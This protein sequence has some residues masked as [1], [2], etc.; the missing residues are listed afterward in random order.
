MLP[1]LPDVNDWGN[2]LAFGMGDTWQATNGGY[3]IGEHVRAHRWMVL[4][5]E[6]KAESPLI[7]QGKYW[8]MTT[9]QAKEFLQVADKL[10]KEENLAVYAPGAE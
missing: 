7:P 2:M 4:L 6:G 5:I 1:A 9:N 3:L 8:L 10:R